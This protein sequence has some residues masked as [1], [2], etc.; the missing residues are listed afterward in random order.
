MFSCVLVHVGAGSVS[1]FER[2][3]EALVAVLR[4]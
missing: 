4:W 1:E 3:I 2:F